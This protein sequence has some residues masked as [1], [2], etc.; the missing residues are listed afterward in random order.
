MAGLIGTLRTLW[1]YVQ[2]RRNFTR[3][4]DRRALEAWQD[5][6][7]RGHLKR[8]LP[9]SA[10]YRERYAGLDLHGWRN[11]PVIEKRDMMEHFDALNTAG[12]RRED[13]F[14]TALHAEESRDFRPVLRGI[15]VGLSSG[16]SGNR[17]IFL[18]SAAEQQRWAGTMLARIL[19]GGLGRSHRAALLL[20]ANSNLYESVEGRRLAFQFFDLFSPWDALAERLARYSPTL[21]VAPPS[22]LLRLADS[23]KWQPV[24]R[25]VAAAEVLEPQDA[26]KIAAAFHCDRVQQIYQATEGFVAATCAHG[27]LHLNEDIIAV[28]REDIGSGRFVPI[29]TDFRR[30]T[31]PIL[32]YRLNDILRHREKP[33][34][35]GSVF[36]AI[37][38]I[39]GRCDDALT[40][41]GLADGAPVEIFADFIRRAFLT[42][43]SAISEYSLTQRAQ[44]WE[45]AFVAP[46][47]ENHAARKAVTIALQNVCAHFAAHCPALAFVPHVAPRPGE[48]LRRIRRLPPRV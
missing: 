12:I 1:N 46:D 4:P 15:T 27:T 21:L 8:I 24:E 31:Q 19:P 34:A 33:C 47:E 35:C 29:L 11:F 17:G 22:A 40:A 30:T 44:T 23:R 10:F 3:W 32:R 42:A 9:Q 16:T 45:V 20:R 36:A 37:E 26:E 13:A 18:A 14:A 5:R 48:K 2:A 7:V 25:V 28:Q 39:E 41:P 43:H 6:Q 38:S